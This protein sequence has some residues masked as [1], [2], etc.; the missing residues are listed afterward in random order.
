MLTLRAGLLFVTGASQLSHGVG[1]GTGV[2]TGVGAGVGLATVTGE[3]VGVGAAG[4]DVPQPARR[5]ATPVSHSEHLFIS[6]PARGAPI[7][8]DKTRKN[9][10]LAAFGQRGTAALRAR[11]ASPR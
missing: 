1:V 9:I 4:V 2:G 6:P 11:A 5:H 3:G 10:A 7:P 8:C